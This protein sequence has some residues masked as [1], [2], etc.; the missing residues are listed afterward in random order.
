MVK[1][2]TSRRQRTLG[3]F[4]TEST[5]T[6]LSDI[7][8]PLLCYWTT[9]TLLWAEIHPQLQTKQN[10]TP[11]V[12]QVGVVVWYS[13]GQQDVNEV[14]RL[15]FMGNPLKG[16]RLNRHLCFD[17]HPSLSSCV[18]PGRD[19]DGAAVLQP[20]QQRWGWKDES[21]MIR[22]L[23]WKAG[24]LWNPGDATWAPDFPVQ[25]FCYMRTKPLFSSNHC[26][27]RFSITRVANGYT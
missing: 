24:S 5:V 6:C 18:E 4:N 10:K 8:S 2:V 26:L 25:T 20:G 12:F 13:S 23:N 21:H 17:L 15:V 3:N 9:L 19:G 27:A 1:A 16:S 11:T 7:H 14:V 22:R